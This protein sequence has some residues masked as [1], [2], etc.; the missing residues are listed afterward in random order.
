MLQNKALFGNFKNVLIN[1]QDFIVT[2]AW[3]NPGYL[4]FINISV[5][6]QKKVMSSSELN[7]ILLKRARNF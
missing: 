7:G 4:N 1:V 6:K 3:L 5:Q 2:K